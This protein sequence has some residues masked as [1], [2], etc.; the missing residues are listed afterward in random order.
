MWVDLYLSA[1]L[2]ALGALVFGRFELHTP[3]RKRLFKLVFYQGIAALLVFTVGR[4]WS[5]LWIFG[6]MAV[7]MIFHFWWT[8][9]HDIHPLKATP[10]DRYY[11]LRGW[12]R[13]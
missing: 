4:P 9:K 8:L 5:L 6:L 2:F 11:Q 7:G 1:L 13:D 12:A 10:Q 3:L